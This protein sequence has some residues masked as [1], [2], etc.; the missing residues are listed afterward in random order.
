[1]LVDDRERDDFFTEVVQ[2]GH[3]RSDFEIDER[4]NPMQGEEVQAVTGTATVTR[5][6]SGR[7][8][9]YRVG[10]GSAWVATHF[11]ADLARGFF[12]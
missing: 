6:F 9:A 1:M 11:S 12:D 10:Y 5:K 4:E 7:Q 3:N 2:A 8:K